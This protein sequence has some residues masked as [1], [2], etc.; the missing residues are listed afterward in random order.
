MK[1]K[2]VFISL[3]MRGRSKEQIE[4][5]I[6]EIKRRVADKYGNEY[7]IEY[8]H[9]LVKEEPP[10]QNKRL[11]YLS[12]SLEILAQADLVVFGEGWQNASGCK[13]EHAC[14][15]EYDIPILG[16]EQK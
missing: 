1:T 14:A 6:E 2:K 15:T 4:A 8:L 11:W 13:I 3:P 16:E 10:A 5:N 7:Q 9:T 12:K